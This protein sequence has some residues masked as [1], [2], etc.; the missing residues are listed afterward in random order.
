MYITKLLFQSL[1][2]ECLTYL[3]IIRI[4]GWK[5]SG[6]ADIHDKSGAGSRM[7]E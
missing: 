5:E 4:W 7:T 2:S 1:E 6:A 3:D